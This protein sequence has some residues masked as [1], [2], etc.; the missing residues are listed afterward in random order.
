M[1]VFLS[2]LL[3][4]FHC[5]FCP[6]QTAV[7]V[8]EKYIDTVSNGDIQNWYKIRSVLLEKEVFY[9][10][11]EY[12][13]S[14]PNIS[15]PTVH[16]DKTYRVF[17]DKSK[18]EI[19]ADS[20]YNELESSWWYLGDRTIIQFKNMPPIIKKRPNPKL[21]NFKPIEILELMKESKSLSNKGVKDFRMEGVF[22]F[23]I[24]VEKGNGKIMHL[25][26]DTTSYLLRFTKNSNEFES[27]SY[28]TYGDYKVIDGLLFY[29]L[30]Y[31]MKNGR[32]F[33]SSRTR[34]IHVNFP[35]DDKKFKPF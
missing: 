16:Y 18:A 6:G 23:D 17:P 3:L 10:Q 30:T 26:F 32:I 35:I 20:T 15:G 9:G 34:K 31:A 5:Q 12:E 29:T 25:Y 13:Q 22:C 24:E 33:F 8:I 14:G 19:Y 7:E 1:R 27:L 11:E 28:A 21:W 4:S 2:T